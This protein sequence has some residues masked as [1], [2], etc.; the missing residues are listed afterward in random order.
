VGPDDE[1]EGMSRPTAVTRFSRTKFTPPPLPAGFVPRPRLLRRLDDTAPGSLRLVVG[2]PGAGKSCL[3]SDWASTRPP[4][5]TVWINADPGDRDP[6]RFWT[7]LL[8]VVQRIEP[9]FGKDALDLL[10]LAPE[11]GPDLLESLLSDA[12]LLERPI[13]VIIDDFHHVA[14]E[15]AGSLGLLLGRGLLGLEL[16]LG[17]RVEPSPLL[18]RLRTQGKLMLIGEQDLR[19][20]LDETRRF[21][22]GLDL[23]VDPATLG[24]LQQRTEGWAAGV[25]LAAMVVREGGWPDLEIDG[26]TG[27]A[28]AIARY[29]VTELLDTQPPEIQRY[30]TDT[31]VVDELTPEL[32]SALSPDSPITLA[33]LEAANLLIGRLDPAGRTFRYHHFFAD[34]LRYRLRASDPSREHVLHRRAAH[35]FEQ[36]GDATTAARHAWLAGS[37]SEA[38]SLVHRSAIDAYFT[39]HP[40]AVRAIALRLSDDDLRMTPAASL[41]LTA[42]IAAEGHPSEA[43]DFLTRLRRL[44]GPT[45]DDDAFEVMAASLA[46]TLTA[47]GDTDAALSEAR[48]PMQSALDRGLTGDWIEV[49]RGM[50]A[51]AACWSGDLGTAE[52]LLAGLPL[53]GPGVLQ[54]V[55]NRAT[56]AHL[57][58]L[59]GDLGQAA[60]LA[61]VAIESAHRLA[62][63]DSSVE[64]PPDGLLGTA[65]LEQGQVGEAEHHLRRALDV[66]ASERRPMTALA[67]MSLSRIWRS[68]GETEAAR[69][70]LV[71][72]RGLFRDRP[73]GRI[74]RCVDLV[75]A[76]LLLAVGAL[77]EAAER[78]GTAPSGPE[79]VVVSALLER[80]RG[81][82]DH[83]RRLLDELEVQTLPVPQQLDV[84]LARL[85]CALDEGGT[86]V[87]EADL[88]L[89]LAQVGGHLFRLAEAGTDVLAALV[90]V[91]RRRPQ[92]ELLR[93]LLVTTPHV[94]ASVPRPARMV[95]PLSARERTVLRYLATAMTYREMADELYVSVNT[96]KTHAKNIVRKLGAPSRAEAVRRARELHYL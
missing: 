10:T 87:A 22:E 88:V 49:G 50:L 51:R 79:R 60:T 20:V 19:L 47:L 24:T 36:N 48:A 80:A 70:I 54:Q 71:D 63:P 94:V 64:A 37:P 18:G 66:R 82:S 6:V 69:R 59:Q 25:V 40:H 67:Q 72:A 27:T 44:F 53:E 77:D 17:S 11:V 73:E 35:W 12:E 9:G 31:C 68:R 28:P 32:A 21:V 43:Y 62:G 90:E 14:P 56:V 38:L 55:E 26:L 65:L 5:A 96:V 95:E 33:D 74:A 57:R 81:R 8:G 83:A 52:A 4:E 3:L 30:L 2:S 16:V 7:G 13:A 42:A 84:A 41:S 78:L 89:E 23:D 34:L 39:G 91:A 15:V 29:L 92:T 93:R 86:T 46:I 85:S 58:L 45:L 61:R 1:P 75:E 76:R